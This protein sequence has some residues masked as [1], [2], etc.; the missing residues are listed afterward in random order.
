MPARLYLFDS[1]LYAKH[2]GAQKDIAERCDSDLYAK[3]LFQI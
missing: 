2:N 3:H 1:D